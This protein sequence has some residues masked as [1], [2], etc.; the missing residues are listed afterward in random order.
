MVFIYWD[1]TTHVFIVG[2]GIQ[3]RDEPTT[4]FYHV[5]REQKAE[6]YQQREAAEVIVN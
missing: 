4:D 3:W 1:E 6:K 2:E 5:I